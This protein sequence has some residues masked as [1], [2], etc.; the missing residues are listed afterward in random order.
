M[1]LTYLGNLLL[2]VWSNPACFSEVYVRRLEI[3]QWAWC[4]W[5]Y[6]CVCV[7]GAGR[8]REC[9]GEERRGRKGPTGLEE[10]EREEK[11]RREEQVTSGF[12]HRLL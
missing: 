12:E 10:T 1:H 7:G 2:C 6:V 11:G 8:G 5:L 9:G 3:V 4:V